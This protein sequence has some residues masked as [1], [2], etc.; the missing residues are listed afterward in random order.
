MPMHLNYLTYS[1]DVSSPD[2][3]IALKF[4]PSESELFWAIPK[5]VSEPF[6]VILN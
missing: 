1:I 6:R 5:S 3:S 2:E 4:I